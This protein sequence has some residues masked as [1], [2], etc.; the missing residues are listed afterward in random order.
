MPH[1]VWCFLLV[2]LTVTS[3]SMALFLEPDPCP[4]S[5]ST[6]VCSGISVRCDGRSL[7]TVPI[8]QQTNVRY[9]LLDLSDNAIDTIGEAAFQNINTTSLDLSNNP[10]QNFDNNAFVGLEDVLEHLEMNSC[11]LTTIPEA[12]AS[13]RRLKT[14]SIR[15]NPGLTTIASSV[16]TLVGVT[17]ENLDFR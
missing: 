15:H 8:F 5:Q 10:I 7:T 4:V 3:R 12:V 13:L 16:M 6:C 1:P 14:L 17:L 9:Q 11:G 2:L